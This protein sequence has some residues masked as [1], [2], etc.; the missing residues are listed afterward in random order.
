MATDTPEPRR[1][2][3]ER[4]IYRRANGVYEIGFKDGTRRQRW[5]TVEGGITA[6]RAVRDELL[7]RRGRGEQ[8]APKTRLT[9]ADAA[10][11]WL[12]GPVRD[13]RPRTDECYRNA[14]NTHLVP[15]FGKRRLDAIT[16]DDLAALVREMRA[17]GFS[18]S[19]IRDR[20]RSH[21]QDLQV[22]RAPTGLARH[23]PRIHVAD[24]RASEAIAIKA[25]P[26]LRGR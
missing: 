15:R 13:L 1:I 7:A 17:M 22:R 5:R 25:A 4:N 14:V 11:A 18:E 9:L 19:T 21:E 12:E 8:V 10:Q 24:L 2:R 16:P 3:V 6:A 20:D 23:E 26:D